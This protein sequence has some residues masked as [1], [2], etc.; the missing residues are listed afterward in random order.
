[1]AQELAHPAGL[2]ARELHLLGGRSRDRPGGRNP[3]R[4]RAQR[5]IHGEAEP[6]QGPRG[7]AQGPPGHR[8]V[9]LHVGSIV[10]QGPPV[11]RPGTRPGDEGTPC[12]DK[13]LRRLVVPKRQVCTILARPV[14]RCFESPSILARMTWTSNR[15]WATARLG[16]LRQ[17]G[18]CRLIPET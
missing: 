16:E 9:R 11:A 3:R 5:R 1:H 4:E 18:G 7:P 14:A 17:R 12:G 13:A 15:G 8:S 2:A 10:A 6:P